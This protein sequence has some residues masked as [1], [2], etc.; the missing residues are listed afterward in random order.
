MKRAAFRACALAALG[1][2][3]AGCGSGSSSPPGNTRLTLS[4]QIQMRAGTTLPATLK[5]EVVGTAIAAPVQ[6]NGLFTLT[7]VPAGVQTI[8]I[9]NT[10]DPTATLLVAEPVDVKAGATTIPPLP[11]PTTFT[12]SAQSDLAGKVY[13]GPISPVEMNGQPND[14]PYAGAMLH[15]APADSSGGVIGG[16]TYDVTSAADGSFSVQVPPGLYLVTPLSGGNGFPHAST[17][18]VTVLAN[19]TS[20]V[21]IEYDTGIR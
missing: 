5:A 19:Q 17:F 13:E 7:G 10:T 4:G 18:L 6:A 12:P 15:I 2:F 1:G 14:K 20:S 16:P 21:V 9:V 8:G 11:T 3:A